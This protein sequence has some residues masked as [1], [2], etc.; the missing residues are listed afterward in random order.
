MNMTVWQNINFAVF[1]STEDVFLEHVCTPKML[2]VKQTDMIIVARDL[3]V[4][5][6][7]AAR[8]TVVVDVVHDELVFMCHLWATRQVLKQHLIATVSTIHLFRMVHGF[9][10]IFG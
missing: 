7:H 6:L 2:L 4:R 8:V 10:F 5:K 1:S 9:S 3:Q